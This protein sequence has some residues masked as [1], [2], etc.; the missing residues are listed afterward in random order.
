MRLRLAFVVD[1]TIIGF[2][3]VGVVVVVVGFLLFFV[4]TPYVSSLRP[5]S[6]KCVLGQAI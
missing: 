2:V 6:M 5:K 3:V 4:V 1:Q